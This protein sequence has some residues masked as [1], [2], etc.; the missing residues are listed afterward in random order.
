M[1]E[2]VGQC[3]DTNKNNKMVSCRTP[4][5]P[6][7]SVLHG[8]HSLNRR[9]AL[10]FTATGI[11]SY[12]IGVVPVRKPVFIDYALHLVSVVVVVSDRHGD[13]HL[14]PVHTSSAALLCTVTQ[15]RE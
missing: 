3:F 11:A 9:Q 7:G 2:T 13:T 10:D 4:S 12:N 6:E 15:A 14:S 5:F 1:S 8:Q